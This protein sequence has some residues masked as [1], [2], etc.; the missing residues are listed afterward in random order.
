MDAYLIDATHQMHI[1]VKTYSRY[2]VAT[3]TD[4]N[5]SFSTDWETLEELSKNISQCL[6][7]HYEHNPIYA[8]TDFSVSLVDLKKWKFIFNPTRRQAHA[9]H[10]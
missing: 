3:G 7:L 5:G 9:T 1:Q 6:Q 2:F 4:S 10:P 8:N